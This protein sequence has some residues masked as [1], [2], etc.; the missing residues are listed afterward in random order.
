VLD[1]LHGRHIAKP[2]P[3]DAAEAQKWL[4]HLT[5]TCPLEKNADA[6]SFTGAARQWRNWLVHLAE[7]G[8][9]QDYLRDR[10]NLLQAARNH[11]GAPLIL[12]QVALAI[13]ALPMN[14]AEQAEAIAQAAKAHAANAKDGWIMAAQA[15]AH[16]RAGK[17]QDAHATLAP[18]MNATDPGIWLLAQSLTALAHRQSGDATRAEVVLKTLRALP[19]ERAR[20]LSSPT[21]RDAIL[22]RVLIREAEKNP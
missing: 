16:I 11:P 2:A 20:L 3:D 8:K 1:T 15:L 6:T 5:S 22:A 18:A 9:Q 10:T 12:S 7:V 17:P 14:D 13:L 4:A 21:N 19:Q